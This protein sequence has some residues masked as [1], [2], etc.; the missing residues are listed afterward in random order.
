I[1]QAWSEYN[2]EIPK[3]DG[4]AKQVIQ[5]AEGYATERINNAQGDATRFKAIYREY[6]RAPLVTRKRLYLEAI[7]EILPKVNRKIIIDENLKNLMPLLN[8]G[9]E[10]IK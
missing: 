6:A 7:N 2:Q 3:A 9:Q 8:L 10:V 1:N 5:A 4:E